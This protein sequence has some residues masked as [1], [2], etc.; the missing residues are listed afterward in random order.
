M[1]LPGLGMWGG[2]DFRGWVFAGF[3]IVKRGA[4]Y[5]TAL[6]VL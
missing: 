6:R 4:F 3:E 2:G 1:G 5:W